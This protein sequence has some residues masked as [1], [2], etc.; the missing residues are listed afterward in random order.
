MEKQSPQKEQKK[1]DTERFCQP[2]GTGLHLF[3]LLQDRMN[4]SGS[5]TF[6]VA[7]FTSPE[8]ELSAP[9]GLLLACFSAQCTEP[10]ELLVKGWM[11]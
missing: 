2:G 3:P 9:P 8:K 4:Q 5:L 1:T 7:Y 10:Q 11:I 6:T